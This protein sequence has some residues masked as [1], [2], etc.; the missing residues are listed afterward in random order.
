M[1]LD[2]RAGVSPGQIAKQVSQATTAM[3]LYTQSAVHTG[4]TLTATTTAEQFYA[5]PS[6][7]IPANTLMVGQSL[8]IKGSGVYTSSPILAPTQT[9]RLWLGTAKMIDS[10]PLTFPVNLT[11]CRYT[12]D[13]TMIV[14]AT[15]TSGAIESYGQLTFATSL[16]TAIPVIGGPSGTASD[17]GNPVAVNTTVD[18]PVR[19]SC[20][21]GSA[22]AG[23]ANSMRQIV[24]NSFKP[25]A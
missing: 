1:G 17:T 13:I 4:D 3:R 15:G 23:N 24:I 20:Q 19:L 22:T 25:P 6:Y 2:L 10:G 11:T 14:R 16:I 5:S 18:L 9:A 8:H 7:S 12:F 21:F